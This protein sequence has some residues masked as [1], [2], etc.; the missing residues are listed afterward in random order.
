MGQRFVSTVGSCYLPQN[1]IGR[2]GSFQ[3]KRIRSRR[4]VKGLSVYLAF[5]LLFSLTYVWIRTSVIRQGY[6]LGEL[7]KKHQILV[8]D[9]K[10]LTVEVATLKSPQR[11]REWAHSLGLQSPEDHQIIFPDSDRIPDT[12][13]AQ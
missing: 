11:L 5:F 12:S 8:E 13:L 4:S 9:Q 6:V 10:K 3:S 1:R 2:Q 7:E